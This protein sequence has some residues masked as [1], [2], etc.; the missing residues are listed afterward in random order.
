MN[1]TLQRIIASVVIASAL[2]I[3]GPWIYINL[4]KDDAPTALK[5]DATATS[6]DSTIATITDATG[7]WT[8]ANM[9]D[10][11]VGYRVREILFGQSTEGVGRTKSVSGELSIANNSVANASFSVDMTTL[12]SDAAKRDAQFNGRIMDVTNYPT[13]TFTLTQPIALPSNATSGDIISVKATG[14][15][16]LRGTTK[17]VTFPVEAKLSGSTFTVVGAIKIVFSEWGIP[18]PGLPGISVDP[19]GLLE[20]ALTFSRG[21]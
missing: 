5:I 21:K 15:L 1:K 4:I 18:E 2:L 12:M 3:A 8:I 13:A 16:L 14:S 11:I 10:S 17:V 20:F 6:V 9:S 7:T 19:D